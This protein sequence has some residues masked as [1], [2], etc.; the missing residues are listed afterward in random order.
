[1]VDF[2]M[3]TPD[4]E[5]ANLFSRQA[6]KYINRADAL[7]VPQ[8]YELFFSYATGVNEA[9]KKKLDERLAAGGGMS[10]SELRMLYETYMDSADKEERLSQLGEQLGDE[11]KDALCLVGQAVDSISDFSSSLANTG[12]ELGDFS[13]PQ[14]IRSVFAML[15]QK[16]QQMEQD[17]QVLKQKLAHTTHQI[18][19][20]QNSLNSALQE[21][22]TDFL[23][24]I[25]NRKCFD[26]TLEKEIAKAKL[27]GQPLCLG[28]IDIDHFKK[29]NDTFGHQ[30]G[31]SVLG[32]VAA[33]LKNTLR[34]SDLAA[35]YGGE[36]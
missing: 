5:Q 9:L 25:A 32:V 18:S 34:E 2:F 10:P 7:P 1:M 21:A 3:Q 20:L 6:I 35:R 15:V 31:D 14:K 26:Q 22:Q 16:T 28:M 27:T 33:L 4:R 12:V 19:R 23:T 24:G 11:V 13:D 17:G 8:N 29:F 30:V 36:E